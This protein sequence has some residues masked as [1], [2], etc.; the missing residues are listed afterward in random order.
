MLHCDDIF[1]AHVAP[2]CHGFLDLSGFVAHEL[3]AF[4]VK[5][6]TR[7]RRHVWRTFQAACF[8]FWGMTLPSRL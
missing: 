7:S 3:S 6:G 1:Y 8:K 4:L 2:V 5:S